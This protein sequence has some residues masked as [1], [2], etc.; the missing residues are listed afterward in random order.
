MIGSPSSSTSS[1]ATSGSVLLFAEKAGIWSLQEEIVAPVPQTGAAFGYDLALASDGQTLL[2]GAPRES[3]PGFSQTGAAYLFAVKKTNG[4][5]C[6]ASSE[7][8]SGSCVD[9]VCCESACGGGKDIDCEACS[10]AKT[11]K[12]DGLCRPVKK[13]TLCRPA[14]PGGCDIEERCSGTSKECPLDVVVKKDTLCRAPAGVCDKPE[15]C[16]GRQATCPDDSK[17]DALAVCRPAVGPCDEPESCDGLQVSCPVDLWSAKTKRCGV[18]PL[19]CHDPA[20]CTGDSV[21]CPPDP[22]QADGT[23]CLPTGT[24]RECVKPGASCMAG[25]CQA[26]YQPSGTAC[27][28]MQTCDAA[29]KC[30]G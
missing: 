7:C 15:Y 6:R 30:K 18:S 21:A 4:D 9:G 24:D 3:E 14:V 17:R 16:D 11:G 20:Y 8:R 26:S 25:A 13:D 5:L 27:G 1:T 23:A 12:A 29:G 22:P 10:M 19:V 28:T 2:V